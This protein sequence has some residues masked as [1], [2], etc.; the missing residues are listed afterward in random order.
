[1]AAVT[2]RTIG[3][4]KVVFLKQGLAVN[5]LAVRFKNIGWMAVRLHY[6]FIPMAVIAG[7]GQVQRIDSALGIGD[8]KNIM[9]TVA[10]AAH[11]CLIVSLKEQFLS[12]LACFIAGQ[13]VR[14]DSI[15]IHGFHIGMAS[16]ARLGNLLFIRNPAEIC[17]RGFC[18]FKIKLGRVSAV[19]AFAGNALAGVNAFLH[20][21][22]EI[23][24]AGNAGVFFRGLRP[25]ERQTDR[26]NKNEEKSGDFSQK[27]LPGVKNQKA[28]L[29]L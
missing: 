23:R 21:I 14:P 3:N 4:R 8:G 17:S 25:A 28:A 13:L 7:F 15:K 20:F 9:G 29:A 18:Q 5:A 22:P 12:V 24:M 1:M 19:A 10:I 6:F 16:A 27:P 26:E 2:A 11:R